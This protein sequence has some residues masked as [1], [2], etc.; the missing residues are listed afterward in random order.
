MRLASKFPGTNEMKTCK[1]CKYADWKL[2]AAGR[3]HPSGDGRCTYQ[4]SVPVIPASMYFLGTPSPCGGH[5]NR[6][7]EFNNHCPIYTRD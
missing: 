3:L 6:K 1:G 2:T 5:I 4:V 7:R